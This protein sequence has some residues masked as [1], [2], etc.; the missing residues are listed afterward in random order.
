MD[1]AQQLALA[2]WAVDQAKKAGADEAAVDV[3]NSR[4]IEVEVREQKV[5]KLKESTQN[6]LSISVYVNHRFSNQT[7]NDLREATLSSFISE[8]VAMAKIPG[9]GPIPNSARSQVL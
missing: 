4:D 3:G 8:A 5:D 9:G 7:T 6:Y 2:R 1:T